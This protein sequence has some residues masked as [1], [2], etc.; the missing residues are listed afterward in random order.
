MIAILGF[1]SYLIPIFFF[2]FFS[3][4]R[5]GWELWVIFFYVLIS[6]FTDFL[7]RSSFGQ[8]HSQQFIGIFTI[9]E[10][11]IFAI[12][13]YASVKNVL[14]KRIIII[15]SSLVLIFLVFNFLKSNKERFDSTL[16]STESLTL[17][18]F[19]VIFFFEEIS[20]PLPYIMYNSS[21]FWIILAILVY[22]SSTLFLFI[23]AG[24]LSE[25][26]KEKY[27]II[28]S[29]SSIISNIIFGIAFLKSRNTNKNST[30]EKSPLEFSNIPENQGN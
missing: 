28:N 14:F 11:T 3:M 5:A 1:A 29:V 7:L 25:G 27:W 6:F 8:R 22:M 19:C 10:F 16:V 24:N 13:F 2:L 9:C 17:I 26:E 12:F 18:I 15:T 30:I 4:K 21:N 23:I 20:K